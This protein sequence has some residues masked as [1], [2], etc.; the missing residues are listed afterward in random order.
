MDSIDAVS[1]SR[2]RGR[3]LKSVLETIRKPSLV[4]AQSTLEKQ[5][6]VLWNAG[7]CRI[8]EIL[9]TQNF[10]DIGHSAADVW[11]KNDF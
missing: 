6:Y 8:T 11:P 3:R 10:T 4:E 7:I 5:K 1:R 2:C 9:P